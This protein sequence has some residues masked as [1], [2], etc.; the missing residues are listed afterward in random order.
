MATTKKNNTPA[1]VNTPA[2]AA[3]AAAPVAA[4]A[5]PVN[6]MHDFC[7]S[8]IGKRTTENGEVRGYKRALKKE[9]FSTPA[10]FDEYKKSVN[11]AAYMLVKSI[12]APADSEEKAFFRNKALSHLKDA[13]HVVGVEMGLN[14][15]ESNIT[16]KHVRAWTLAGL[17]TE[18]T[19]YT[20]CRREIVEKSFRAVNLKI[21]LDVSDILNGRER[22]SAVK[23]NDKIVEY[24]AKAENTATAPAPA[25]AEKPAP[26]PAAAK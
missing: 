5:A 19:D 23:H 16:K 21:T 18:K 22:V 24:I 26:A 8:A 11:Y 20:T 2:P 4:P 25:P 14:G 1:P 7:L 17:F 10:L 9:V 3:P 15:F 13:Y 6:K 12:N